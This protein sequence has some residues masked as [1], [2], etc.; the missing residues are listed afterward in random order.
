MKKSNARLLLSNYML[1]GT[2]SVL[3]FIVFLVLLIYLIRSDRADTIHY[4][5]TLLFGF[6][7]IGVTSISRHA[8]V[9][10]KKFTGR[11]ISTLEFLSTQL[12]VLL[13]PLLYSRL[14]KEVKE[15]EEQ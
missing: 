12:V 1:W 10:L 3:A 13:F 7:W 5:I 11:K 4:F 15:Y 14:K 6:L 8:F 9:L 2:I